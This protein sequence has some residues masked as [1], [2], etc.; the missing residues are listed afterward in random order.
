MLKLSKGRS[1]RVPVVA[2]TLDI[3]ECLF[4]SPSDLKLADIVEQTNIAHSTAYRILRTLEERGYV[5]HCL[6]GGYRF[7]RATAGLDKS[8]Q[9]ETHCLCTSRQQSYEALM[10]HTI[11]NLFM[12]LEE[13]RHVHPIPLPLKSNSVHAKRN[14]NSGKQNQVSVDTASFTSWK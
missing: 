12:L 11:E 4:H 13:S 10:K 2:R 9:C 3:L 6:G 14:A 1:Y 8:V 5:S 7:F